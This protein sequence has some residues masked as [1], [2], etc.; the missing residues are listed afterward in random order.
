[1]LAILIGRAVEQGLVTG[2]AKDQREG[3]VAILQYA[4]DTILLFQDDL[5]QARNAKRILI[6][7]QIMSGLKINFHKSEMVRV[8]MEHD[9]IK[10]FEEIFT[11][12]RGSFPI[13]YLG[14]PVDEKRLKNSDWNPLVGKMEKRMG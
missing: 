8:G 11:C 12:G 4:D 10:L 9:K 3:D 2:L 14:I 1:M 13:K 6:M 5:E 7:F